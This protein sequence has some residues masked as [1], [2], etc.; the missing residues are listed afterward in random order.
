MPEYGLPTGANILYGATGFPS[1]VYEL[2]DAFGL[3]A[4]TYPGHQEG[5]RAEKGFAPNPNRLNRGIDWTGSV[6]D[7][8]RFA[9]YLLS[10]RSHLEQVI[11]ENPNTGQRVGVAGGDDVTHTG[12]YAQDYSG[13]RDHV[14]TRQSQPIPVP[15]KGKTVGWTGDPTW[16]ETVL[17]E[18]L[19]DRLV[20]HKG[21]EKRGTGAGVN[22]TNQMGNIWGVMIHHTGSSKETPERI[23]DGVWQSPTYFLPGPLSQCLITPDGKCHLVA[24]G[25]CNHAGVGSY[26][27]VPANAGNTSLI[28]FECAWPTIRPDGTWDAA[29]RWPD[30]QIITMRDA[31]AAVLT[32]LGVGSDRVIGH[33]EW[34][35]KSQGKWDPGNIDMGWFRDEVG[36]AQRGDFKVIEPKKEPPAPAPND[37]VVPTDRTELE[38][39]AFIGDQAAL[40]RVLTLAAAGDIRARLVVIRI[41]AA[42]PAALQ[43]FKGAVA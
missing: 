11:W 30:A 43:Q 41:E 40:A 35:G 5:Q 14:H 38:W 12:Y 17:R 4:S 7:M 20:V 26:P 33:K 29:E 1:W 28:G 10:I 23:R 19:G 16:L 39:L 42:N 34:A 31:T 2:G 25:P 6:A 9:D 18:N 21:W 22:G 37:A 24:I 15:A 3:K 32:R 13:H 8:Q 36:K 27:G